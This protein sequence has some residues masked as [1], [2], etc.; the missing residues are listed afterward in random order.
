MNSKQLL[1][2]LLSFI[3]EQ[4][5]GEEFYINRVLP[6]DKRSIAEIISD[7]DF[8]SWEKLFD[9]LQVLNPESDKTITYKDEYLW[10]DICYYMDL[11]K[12]GEEE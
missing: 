9:I 3:D 5:L 6:K 11:L 8:D 2:E 4:G 12:P 1:S 7:T 10:D